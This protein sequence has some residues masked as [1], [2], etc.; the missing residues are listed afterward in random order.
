MTAGIVHDMPTIA[1]EQALA[2]GMWAPQAVE[3]GER[4]AEVVKV[5]GFGRPEHSPSRRGT[6]AGG[7]G[8]SMRACMFPACGGSARACTSA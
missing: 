1:C 4:A 7:V 3:R 6:S 5:A 8:C 2:D